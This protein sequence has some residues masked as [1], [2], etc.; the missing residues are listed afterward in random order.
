MDRERIG[1]VISRL[2]RASGKASQQTMLVA[3]NGIAAISSSKDSEIPRAL[4]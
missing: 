4:L 3:V 2:S 1:I